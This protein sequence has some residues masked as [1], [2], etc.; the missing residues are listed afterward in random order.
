MIE[1]VALKTGYPAE[2]IDLDM[3]LDADLGI[4]SIKRVE[5]LSAWQERLPELP[6]VKP[7]QLGSF[8]TLRTLV[9]FVARA[10]EKSGSGP[11][12][13]HEANGKA[14]AAGPNGQA[15]TG[16]GAARAIEQVLITAVAEK[17]GYP[18][19][20]LE[21][22][23]RL[24]VDLGIDSI[25]RVEILS[26]VQ[27]RLPN[28]PAIGAEQLG[29]F[30]TL[31]QVV[32][33]LDAVA[34]QPSATAVAADRRASAMLDHSNGLAAPA[35]AP[36]QT[37][38]L[39]ARQLGVADDRRAVGLRAGADIWIAA[40]GS[41]LTEAVRSVLE[42]R[43]YRP[44]VFGCG[45]VPAGLA[46]EA[47]GGL[48]VI[49]PRQPRDEAC[50]KSAFR[51]IRAAGP[52][53]H[54]ASRHGGASLLT[55]ARLDGSFGACGLPAHVDPAHGAL[56]GMVKTAGHEWPGVSCKAADLDWAFESDAEAA[57]LIVDEFLKRGPAEVGLTARGRF[58]LELK[59]AERSSAGCGG[60]NQLERGDLVVISGGARG[61]TAVVARALARV[62]T[63][64][65]PARPQP[66]AWRRSVVARVS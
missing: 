66:G 35:R 24:D 14:H 1:V 17:T 5:I 45:E 21:L 36:L 30:S 49:A 41:S 26:A 11:A 38:I 62:S 15:G 61:I 42:E 60:P 44:R 27:E 52:A 25:K 50:V 34:P 28:A 2:V 10:E 6:A 51:I 54:E 29:T 9:E 33:A 4:D 8:R 56:A 31:R 32:E 63:H 3:Q 40:D 20:M 39:T 12:R 7:E 48:I 16:T 58:A 18:P 46:N 47:L 43:G 13:R 22:D 65:G 19:E 57:R 64:A 23:M 53:L 59:R 37:S 55:V